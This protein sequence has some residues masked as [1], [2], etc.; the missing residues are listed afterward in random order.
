MITGG[1]KGRNAEVS[2]N[3]FIFRWLFFSS[4]SGSLSPIFPLS[5]PLPFFN[6]DRISRNDDFT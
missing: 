2:K 5:V 4:V 3:S 1:F 6:P